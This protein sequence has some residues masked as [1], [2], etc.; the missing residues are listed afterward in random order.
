MADRTPGGGLGLG[1]VLSFIR[2]H[3]RSPSFAVLPNGG[4][5]ASTCLAA[6]CR[7]RMR[8]SY[9]VGSGIDAASSPPIAMMHCATDSK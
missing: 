1:S 4:A 8:T 6:P 2:F 9:F 5:A 7:L 3:F